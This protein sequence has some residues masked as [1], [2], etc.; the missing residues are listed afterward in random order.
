MVAFKAQVPQ[1]RTIG[2]A[3]KHAVQVARVSHISKPKAN[4][5]RPGRLHLQLRQLRLLQKCLQRPTSVRPTTE[6]SAHSQPSSKSVSWNTDTYLRRLTRSWAHHFLC[7]HFTRLL[8]Q[9]GFL[10]CLVLVL[11]V[12]R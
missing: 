7:G 5:V 2:Q 6:A 8:L 3:L 10:V 9:Q 12:W 1:W 4:P 11:P